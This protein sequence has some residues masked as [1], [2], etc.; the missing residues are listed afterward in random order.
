MRS[1]IAA[2]L[3]ALL[4][5][6]APGASAEVVVREFRGIGQTETD[7]F[8]VSSPWLLEW[9]SRPPSA[10]D[11]KPAHLE[12]Y[13]YNASTSEFL[14][15][16][17][18]HNGVGNGDVLIEHEGRFRL[19]VQGQATNWELRVIKV[20]EEY[21]ERLRETRPKPAERRRALGW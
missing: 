20:D 2:G 12:V 19:R 7:V 1:W 14:G 9:W 18:R 8:Y 10:I 3:V 4:L 11:E 21:A 13:L 16:V 5:G 6:A 15:R 17:M